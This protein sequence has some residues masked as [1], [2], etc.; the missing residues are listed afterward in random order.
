MTKNKA[1]KRTIKY[2]IVLTAIIILVIAGKK[3]WEYYRKYIHSKRLK[4]GVDK[5]N[6]PGGLKLKNI[7]QPVKTLV[8]LLIKNFS[9][10]T[11]TVNQI[12]AE[13]YTTGG[14]LIA[15]Q[16]SPIEKP[17]RIEPNKNTP[18]TLPFNISAQAL[19]QL[20]SEAGGL[21]SVAANFLTTGKYGIAFIIKGFV[22]AEN[23]KLDINEKIS[24]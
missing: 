23:I 11:F 19:L 17:F 12:N 18:Y 9:P 7:I 4:T 5:I 3:S 22:T 8:T 16:D 6:I 1:M 21:T 14:T 15:E 2:L 10:S 20:I 13:I 24:I